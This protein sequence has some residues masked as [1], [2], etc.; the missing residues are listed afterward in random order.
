[1]LCRRSVLTGVAA[2]CS[3][4]TVCPG[5]TVPMWDSTYVQLGDMVT[6][7]WKI[8]SQKT[9][10]AVP[11]PDLPTGT[12]VKYLRIFSNGNQNILVHAT[13]PVKWQDEK[14]GGPYGDFNAA[15]TSRWWYGFEW[16]LAHGNDRT[17][18]TVNK[19][20]TAGQI[21]DF[22]QT[23]DPGSITPVFAF[24]QNQNQGN[25]E[26]S[27]LPPGWTPG[28][29]F[30]PDIWV[31]GRVLVVDAGAI[32]AA[33]GGTGG[34]D[35]L[36]GMEPE[37]VED[38]IDWIATNMPGGLSV[39]TLVDDVF[40][41]YPPDW[42]YLPGTYAIEGYEAR[43]NKDAHKGDWGGYFPA[44]DLSAPGVQDDAFLVEFQTIFDNN[45]Q[46]EVYIVGGFIPEPLTA[47]G[48]LIGVGGLL[49][50]LR[51]RAAA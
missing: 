51:R 50:Y 37:D 47:A 3:F 33:T 12:P 22:I 24:D 19:V 42:V 13:E 10:G 43:N 1:M 30:A 48:V 28:T 21:Y 31:R 2:V 17:L 35:E 44:M 7:N 36:K 26:I 49:G 39:F 16:D 20:L 23:L 29:G 4:C 32:N 15:G 46:E 38:T 9:G 27:P 8:M 41:D 6:F 11:I 34:A 40:L 5:L 14:T 45:G 18:D 25:S